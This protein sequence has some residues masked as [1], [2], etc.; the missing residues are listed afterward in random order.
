[1][2]LD[3]TLV[4]PPRAAKPSGV[5]WTLQRGRAA[6]KTG[7]RSWGRA[8]WC[9]CLVSTAVGRD[10]GADDGPAAAVEGRQRGENEQIVAFSRIR[11]HSCH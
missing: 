10:A 3:I 5:G 4:T 2:L 7:I 1:V 11:G 9:R 8:M 6:R